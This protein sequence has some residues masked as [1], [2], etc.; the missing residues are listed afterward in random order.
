MRARR[1]V[2]LARHL[3]AEHAEIVITDPE[4]LEDARLDTA[5]LDGNLSFEADPYAAARGA[6]AVAILTEW[7]VYRTLDYKQLLASM[8]CPNFLFESRNILDH[9]QLFDMGVN[10]YPVGKRPMSH[11]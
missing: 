10:V 4:A 8:E 6:H 3:L 5:G 7:D 9:R 1:A 2:A 11:V